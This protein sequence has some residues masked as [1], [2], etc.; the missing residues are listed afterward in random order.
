[1]G[2]ARLT[3]KRAGGAI[4]T[5][6]VDYAT[7]DG[8]ARGGSD[9]TE[10]TGTLTFAP[11]QTAQTISVT[12]TDDGLS[13]GEEYFRVDLKD[14]T[15]GAKLSSASS[16]IVSIASH[17]TAVQFLAPAFSVSEAATRAD[18]VVKRTGSLA[19]A[20]EVSYLA[21]DGTA[22][23]NV[24]YLA[25]SG[26]LS[27]APGVATRTFAVKLVED[28][29]FR[30]PRTVNLGLSGPSSGDLGTSQAELTIR[31]DDP[32]GRV[33][34]AAADVSVSE[35]AGSATVKIV[36]S[37]KLAAGQTVELTTTD[38]TAIAGSH[39]LNSS[40][41]LAFGPGEKLKLVSIPVLAD[42]APGGG[43]RSVKLGLS[44]PAGG[45]TVAARAAS[46][47]WIVGAE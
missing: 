41:T 17:D 43:A 9:Y 38:G 21:S 26:T 40:Q 8:S 25:A 35:S 19:E 34:F 5:V 39:Y 12:V 16:A 42:G 15:G 18:I 23:E 24:D 27:F 7:A 44:S 37:G 31:D 22:L 29:A 6:T 33:E 14:P 3:V 45:A 28:A 36:R 20:L 32:P 13:D 11:G 2:Q 1:M 4:G 30:G 46:T 10:Q 47:L